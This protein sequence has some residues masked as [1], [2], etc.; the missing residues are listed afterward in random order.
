LPR[1]VTLWGVITTGLTGFLTI[2]VLL[3]V[4]VPFFLYLSYAPFEFGIGVWML[5][6]NNKA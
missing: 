1:W 6:R 2:A 3:G 5:V 4:E